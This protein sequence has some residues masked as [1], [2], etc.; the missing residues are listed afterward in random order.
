M[1]LTNVAHIAT[2]VSRIRARRGAQPIM[3][4]N[5]MGRPASRIQT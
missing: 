1:D 5:V 4:A 2:N 3:Y